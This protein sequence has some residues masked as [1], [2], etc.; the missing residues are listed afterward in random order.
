MS[1]LGNADWSAALQRAFGIRGRHEL[2]LSGD[3][4]PVVLTE[5]ATDPW[6]SVAVPVSVGIAYG[7]VA[8]Q[9]PFAGVDFAA[10]APGGAR[11]VIDVLEFSAGNGGAVY[12]SLREADYFSGGTA[13]PM[14]NARGSEEETTMARVRWGT[15]AA[16]FSP[17][18]SLV[19]QRVTAAANEVLEG[20]FV[21][22][23][24]MM[25]V[26]GWNTAN[27]D[28]YLNVRGRLYLGS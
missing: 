17:A 4:L 26:V 23:P 7:A 11:L 24:G 1:E 14:V 20:P 13:Q 16:T 2:T 21:V 12:V 28:L 3:V 22:K 25:L 9:R 6:V 18:P 19:I 27:M 8:G 15:D 5:D 10:N